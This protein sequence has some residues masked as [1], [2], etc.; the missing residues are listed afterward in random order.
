MK[1][2]NTHIGSI[3]KMVLV[4]DRHFDTLGLNKNNTLLSGRF[5]TQM[6]GAQVPGF[7]CVGSRCQVPDVRGQVPGVRC[8][9]PGVRC[10]VPCATLQVSEMR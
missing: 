6:S 3:T 4:L 7:R 5:E 9:A 2:Y 1:L 10:R 8:Q